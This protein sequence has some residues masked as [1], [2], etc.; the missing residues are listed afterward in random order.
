MR[1]HHFRL[2][3][4]D[5]SP[6]FS[7]PYLTNIAPL[8]LNDKPCGRVTSGIQEPQLTP[9]LQKDTRLQKTSNVKYRRT[10][11]GKG[12]GLH[13]S[14][15][16]GAAA[17]LKGTSCPSGKLISWQHCYGYFPWQLAE[18]TGFQEWGGRLCDGSQSEPSAFA[19]KATYL[20]LAGFPSWYSTQESLITNY[21]VAKI[22]PAPPTV[23]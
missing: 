19:R 4:G 8:E 2:N 10:S 23:A 15:V 7:A 6:A 12:C 16:P 1:R 14:M 13:G 11:K 18:P 17:A 22:V 21:A 9:G 3:H 20:I 5:P